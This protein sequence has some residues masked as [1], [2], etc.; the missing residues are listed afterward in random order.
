ML[1]EPPRH[2]VSGEVID[3]IALISWPMERLSESIASPKQRLELM[4]ISP[5]RMDMIDS[6]NILWMNPKKESIARIIEISKVTG[7]IAGLSGVDIDVLALALENNYSLIT[8]DYRMLNV[9]EYMEMEW[10]PVNTEGIKKIWKWEI[11]CR[12]CKKIQQNPESPYKNKD[13]IGDC[14]DCGLELKM[15]KVRL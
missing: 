7:D 10:F 15:R 1:T 11:I 2:M 13:E 14:V 6:I 3:T 5:E 12:G 9:A 8:D 4:R